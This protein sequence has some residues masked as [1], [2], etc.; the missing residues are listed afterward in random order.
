MGYTPLLYAVQ[1]NNKEAAEL[2]INGGA[3][4]NVGDQFGNTLLHHAAVAGQYDMC[5][6]LLDN[7]ANINARN[8]MG[9]TALAMAQAGRHSQVVQLLSTYRPEGSASGV[10]GNRAYRLPAGP[11]YMELYPGYEQGEEGGKIKLRQKFLPGTY[12]IVQMNLTNNVTQMNNQTLPIQLSKNSWYEL[13]ASSPDA[14]GQMICNITVKRVKESH[15][16]GTFDTDDPES[17]RSDQS[18]QYLSSILESEFLLKF[19]PDWQ[20][21][22]ANGLDQ[23]WGAVGMEAPTVAPVNQE[24][25]EK[26]DQKSFAKWMFALVYDIMPDEPVGVGDIWHKV[27]SAEYPLLG[28][29]QCS[30]ECKLTRMEQNYEGRVAYITFTSNIESDKTTSTQIGPMLVTVKNVKMKQTGQVQLNTDTGLML[31][32]NMERTGDLEMSGKGPDGNDVPMKMKLNETSLTTTKLIAGRFETSRSRYGQYESSHADPLAD[33]NEIKARIKTFAGLEEALQ[34]IDSKSRLE[35]SAWLQTK[36]DNRTSMARAVEEQVKQELTFVRNIAVEEKAEKTTKA[37]DD[38][39]STREERYD[40]VHRELLEQKKA[41]K[42]SLDLRGRSRSRYP[43][44]STRGRY[45]PITRFPGQQGREDMAGPY[46]ERDGAAR[47]AYGFGGELD[48]RQEI[49]AET[50]NQIR[51]WLQ[52]TVENK[53]NLLKSVHTEIWTQYTFIREIA[54]EEGA[55]KTTAAIDGLLL[56]RQERFDDLILR[57]EGDR[58]GPGPMRDPQGRYRGTYPGPGGRYPQDRYMRGQQ[59]GE[60]MMGHEQY[61]EQPPT[62]PRRR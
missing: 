51:E 3:D 57:M 52:T 22:D 47:G 61:L 13:D 56:N 24:M 53:N 44:R 5:K 21:V 30:T 43:S 7:G 46:A 54:V 31:E 59:P 33:P 40:K 48:E 8:L 26:M 14:S 36:I 45:P 23:I 49:D 4:V 17:V 2:L 27:N 1:N 60:G 6:L 28:N 38:V 20:L 15:A 19:G 12:E 32:Q 29:I 39:L 16:G 35:K 41:L 37:I 9:G 58:M 11:D 50:E 62:K 18:G 55:K 10:T 25:K 34:Q 42:E